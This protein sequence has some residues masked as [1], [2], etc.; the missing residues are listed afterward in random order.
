MLFDLV[1]W[2]EFRRYD[3]RVMVSRC[4]SLKHLVCV[5]KR[6]P[7][8]LPPTD[9]PFTSELAHRRCTEFGKDCKDDDFVQLNAEV[10]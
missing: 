1:V 4:V 5:M 8:I 9:K 7:M 6:I 2:E 3:F 10:R